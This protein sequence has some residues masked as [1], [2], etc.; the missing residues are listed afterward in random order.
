M[1]SKT[2]KETS[3]NRL[4]PLSP[5]LAGSLLLIIVTAVYGEVSWFHFLPFWDDDT[6]I[7]RNPLYS[8]LSW[9]S[10]AVFWKGPFQQL[11]I[12]VTYSAWGGLVALSRMFAGTGISFGPINPLFFH[13]ANLL[14]HLLSATMIFL[15]LRRLL[16]GQFFKEASGA[17]ITGAAAVGALVFALHP[18]Q[19]EPVAWVSGLRDLLGGAF[20]LVA[21]ACFL[22]FLDEEH[23]GARRWLSY[24]TATLFLLL[25][26]GSKPGSVV[27]P[28]ISLLAGW[29][30]LY[31]RQRSFLS[32]L[33]L[34]PWFFLAG[35]E[36]LL[37]SRSQP[38]A[39]LAA[40]LVPLWARPLVATDAT[41]FYMGKLIW[42]AWP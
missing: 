26:F 35:L 7:H 34:L 25:A 36:V 20:S 18:I 38:A 28:A 19:V 33:W 17:R 2:K 10:I 9:E 41:A 5:L 13:A 14:V 23:R 22:A 11:Y 32:L 21:I 31:E 30:L 24:A 4:S 40:S 12:P 42:P 37:T 29:W 16:A 1:R 6:N 39:E 15:I 8:P 27:A 3:S